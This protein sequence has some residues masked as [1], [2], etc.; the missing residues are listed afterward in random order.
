MLIAEALLFFLPEVAAMPVLPKSERKA[1]REWVVTLV[2]D[3]V[4]RGANPRWH[5]Q[6]CASLVRFAV[7]ESLA[8]HDPKWKKANGFTGRALPPEIEVPQ[9]ERSQFKSWMNSDGKRGDY[10]RALPLIQQNA[11]FLGK[12]MDRIEPA[13]LLFFDQ[14]DDQ[15]VMVWTGRRLVYHTGSSRRERA[16]SD[17]G[18]RAVTM[19]DLLSW[20]DSRWRPVPENPNFVGFYRLAFLENSERGTP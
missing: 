19:G 20:T 15:H 2:E 11:V 13:D 4:S 17:S 7:G 18:L 16:D 12:T 14:G 5:Q 1:F 6:D 8:R 3:Q 10:V 9:S